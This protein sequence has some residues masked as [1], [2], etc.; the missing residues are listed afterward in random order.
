MFSHNCF[1]NI[2]ISALLG[3]LLILGGCSSTDSESENEGQQRVSFSSGNIASDESYSFTFQEEGTVDYYCEI[4]APDMQGQITVTASADSVER[5]TVIM[6]N[7]QFQPSNLSVAPGT[8]VVWIN[9]D[10]VNHRI[11]NGNPSSGDDDDDGGY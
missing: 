4:H 5:D 1:K 3:V 6:N 8:E 7:L 10:G 2:S 11:V 9:N